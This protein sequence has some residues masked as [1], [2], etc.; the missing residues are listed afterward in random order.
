MVKDYAEGTQRVRRRRRK[1]GRME[2]DGMAIVG[3]GDNLRIVLV[4]ADLGEHLL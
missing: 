1:K 2:R 4:H 3:G